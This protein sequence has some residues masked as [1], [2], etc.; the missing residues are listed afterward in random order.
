[1]EPTEADW[2]AGYESARRRNEEALRP[3]NDH[4]QWCKAKDVDGFNGV[5][6]RTIRFTGFEGNY[7]T[8]APDELY[9][10]C[11]KWPVTEAK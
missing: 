4:G 1:M 10:W 5:L 11:E 9:I 3:L 2:D 8:Y 7:R 6:A